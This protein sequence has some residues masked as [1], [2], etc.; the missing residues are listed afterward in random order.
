MSVTVFLHS[1]YNEEQDISSNCLAKL[2][3]IRT[4]QISAKTSFRSLHDSALKS[5]YFDDNV[6]NKQSTMSRS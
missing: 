3:A 6:T 4:P 1:S 5:Y 2:A